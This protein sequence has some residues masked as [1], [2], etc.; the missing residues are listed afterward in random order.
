MP[1]KGNPDYI[2][3]PRIGIAIAV[4]AFSGFVLTGISI[5]AIATGTPTGQI[6]NVIVPLVASWVGTVMAFYFGRE[7][8]ESANEQTRQLVQSL[9]PDQEIAQP[10]TTAMRFLADMTFYSIPKDKTEKDIIIKDL[11]NLITKKN[12]SRLPILS[13]DKKPK[14]MLHASSIDKYLTIT[15]KTEDGTLDDLLV[16]MKNQFKIEFGLNIGFVIVSESATLAEAKQKMDAIPIC[17]DI[18]VTKS[19]SPDEPLTGW[20][21]NLRLGKYT[22]A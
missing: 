1:T 16:E 13:T 12:I 22:E 6:F 5:A 18:F 2:Y 11:R 19:G 20:L 4:L 3:K 21:S 15:G 14:Y 9:G 7:N 17:Q 10:V 8:F